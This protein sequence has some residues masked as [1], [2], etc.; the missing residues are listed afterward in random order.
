VTRLA[1][2]G[3]IA[4]AVAAAGLVAFGGCGSDEA[5][6]LSSKAAR[7]V[8]RTLFDDSSLHVR[9]SHPRCVEVAAPWTFVC[10]V[11]RIG[12]DRAD[13][14]LMAIGYTPAKQVE[15]GSATGLKP[16]PVACA[17]DVRCWV[18]ELCHGSGACTVD[19]AQM[20][21]PDLGA[22]A[23]PEP[24]TSEVCVDAWNVHGG[25]SQEQL[26]GQEPSRP[27]REVERPLYTPHLAAT[28]LGFIGYRA[29][30]RVV[31]GACSVVFDLGDGTVYAIDATVDH[32]PRFW[33]WTGREETTP[34]AAARPSWNACQAADG[35]LSLG[36]ACALDPGLQAR[37]VVDELGR[38][39][40]HRVSDFGGIPYWLGPVF[41]G[42]PPERREP[43]RGKDAVG[44]TVQTSDGPLELLVLTYRPPHR[45]VAAPGFEVVRAHPA[46]ATV[47]VVANRPPPRRVR[48]AA[49]AELR[50]FRSSDPYA[51]QVPGDLAEEPTR[52][53]TAVRV[54][55]YW[56]GPAVAGLRAEV[57]E[58][59]P[60]G[61]GV[62]R[63]GPAG[64]PRT[65]Y[66][67][68]YRPRKKTR[69]SSSG[70]VSPPEPPAALR[71]YGVR[72]HAAIYSDW[73]VDIHAPSKKLTQL[74]AP[75]ALGLT[76]LR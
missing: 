33:T 11:Q 15:A 39:V 45:N 49:R 14:P 12:L 54:R 37:D 20:G 38:R 59:A 23:A 51:E 61:L 30:I 34:I 66:V 4:T 16:I 57:V 25:F 68:T 6:N 56:A 65:F 64:G 43:E 73:I 1:R 71:R 60:G 10:T 63:Y 22:N 69:C 7:D 19:P 75:V 29:D 52:I 50:P 76:R 55:V 67:V 48:R 42:A 36:D 27:D 28:T 70:C 44:Y 32:A 40:L 72:V 13:E 5:P 62:V 18:E 21:F 31:D 9:Y 47:L 41:L 8:E 53:D 35:T 58:G 3:S 26:A 2:I 24:I 17:S 74:T 46:S